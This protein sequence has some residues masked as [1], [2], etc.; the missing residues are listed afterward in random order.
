MP[1][2]CVSARSA[3]PSARERTTLSSA[4]SFST[5]RVRSANWLAT[6]SVSSRATFSLAG[7]LGGRDHKVT[8]REGSRSPGSSTRSGTDR[9]S[10][11]PSAARR[12]LGRE[13]ME[14]GRG[15]L[16]QP[17]H[18]ARAYNDD[19]ARSG[20]RAGRG[21]EGRPR[22]DTLG[23][24][25][26][27]VCDSRLRVCPRPTRTQR[28][29]RAQAVR[30]PPRRPP[31]ARRRA[32]RPGARPEHDQEHAHAAPRD[33]PACGRRWRRRRQSD[34]EASS[35]WRSRPARSDR[36]A[37]GGCHAARHPPRRG[38]TPAA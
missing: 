3:A 10:A 36:L 19:P 38:P 7:I 25:V 33:L 11:R 4:A 1:S 13:G 22:T 18:H 8:L 26:Q 16:A 27:A 37:H 28:P 24:P 2:C 5:D 30:D 23:R 6:I 31:G 20:A 17:R 12:A 9:R 29:R 14:G 32:P 21:D 35:S 34:R 15:R